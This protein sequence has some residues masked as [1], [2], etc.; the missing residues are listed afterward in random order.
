MPAGIAVVPTKGLRAFDQEDATFYVHL[1]PGPI[2]DG[3]P[4]SIGFWK[5]RIEA[6]DP[7]KFFKVGLIYGPSGCGKSSLVKAGVIPHLSPDRIIPV[8]VEAA[9]NTERRLVA[10]LQKHCSFLGPEGS[11]RAMLKR[12]HRIPLN[13][14]IVIVLDQFEQYL[15][16]TSQADQ[17]DLIEAFTECDGAQVLVILMACDDFI[18]PTTRSYFPQVP[19]GIS[20]WFRWAVQWP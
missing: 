8:Y 2:R 12:K 13:K 6:A 16:A 11:L 18:T 20:W 3:L 15:H 19:R 9:S 17:T 4:E 10:A 5:T 7:D 14:K 1:L